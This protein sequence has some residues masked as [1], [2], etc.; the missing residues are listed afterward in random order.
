MTDEREM[1][2]GHL[3]DDAAVLPDHLERF[4]AAGFGAG[5]I[6]EATTDPLSIIIQLQPWAATQ[7]RAG[8]VLLRDPRTASAADVLVRGLLELFAH[9]F[10]IHEE[11]TRATRECRAVCFA[12]GIVR[13][14]RGFLKQ[15]APRNPGAESR[16]TELEAIEGEIQR[17]REH[18]KCACKARKYTDVGPTLRAASQ[19]PDLAWT[20]D[21]WSW[22]STIAHQFMPVVSGPSHEVAAPPSASFME[23]GI[24]LSHFLHVFVNFGIILLEIEHREDILNWRD[25][26]DGLVAIEAFKD[27]VAGRLD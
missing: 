20:Y 19:R 15:N 1:R 26:A 4:V 25:V 11:R 5:S 8:V 14:V 7:Y 2:F 3:L 12:L 24:L 9:V 18:R 16:L 13:T 23:R 27:A 21:T 10:W 22:T 6:E 17:Q